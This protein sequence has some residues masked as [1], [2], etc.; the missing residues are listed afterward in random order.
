[1]DV[2]ITG[3]SGLIG[4][5]LSRSLKT[6]GH[7]VISAGRSGSDKGDDL[8]WDVERGFSSPERLE[9]L[10]AIVHLAGENISALRWTDAK[11][12]SI[13]ASRVVGTRTVVDAIRDLKQKPKVLVSGSGVGFYG[14]RGDEVLTEESSSGDT[15]LAGVCQEWEAEARKADDAGVRVVLART[16]IVLSEKGGALGEML[17]PFRLGVGGVIGSGKQW[18]SWIALDDVVRAIEFAVENENIY[19]PINLTAPNPVQNAEFVKTLGNVLHRPTILPLPT[20]AVNL[21]FGEMGD[22]LLLEST[23][24]LPERVIESGFMFSHEKLADALQTALE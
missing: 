17:T 12:Q 19:G 5:A 13:R 6:A 20:F 23:R 4:T 1:M 9:G 8:R 14:S 2:L 10:D 24:A 15:F 22:S 18:M 21:L 7:R 16:G 11:K 3:A